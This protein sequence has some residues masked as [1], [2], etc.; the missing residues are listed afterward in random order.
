[1]LVVPAGLPSVFDL[2]GLQSLT[3]TFGF[4]DAKWVFG[5]LSNHPIRSTK[6][7]TDHR[8]DGIGAGNDWRRA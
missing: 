2:N 6:T 3:L 8:W 7:T 4:F 1:M 5:T